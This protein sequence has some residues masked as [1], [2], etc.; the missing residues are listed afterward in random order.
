MTFVI[1]LLLISFQSLSA[2][3][4]VNVTG[5]VSSGDSALV[6]VT[7]QVKGGTTC[8]STT[9]DGKYSINVPDSATIV[10]SQVNFAETEIKVD[11]RNTIDVEMAPVNSTLT[12]VVVVGYNSQRKATITGSISTVKGA[13]LVKSPQ[14]NLSNS[15]AGR[16]S[17]VIINNRSGEPGYDG[18]G[19]E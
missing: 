1:W 15:L 10:F 19:I 13:E 4:Q 17:G 11:G 12:D 18:S 16:F 7:V 2:F 5:K 9:A 14:P 6:N 8:T 3:S